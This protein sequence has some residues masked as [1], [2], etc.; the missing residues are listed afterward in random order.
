VAA[1]APA[2]LGGVCVPVIRT[3]MTAPDV[4]DYFYAPLRPRL[5]QDARVAHTRRTSGRQ[6]SVRRPI[7]LYRSLMRIIASICVLCA[8][9][10]RKEN[11]MVTAC[12]LIEIVYH[13]EWCQSG[14]WPLY[15]S[16]TNL[17]EVSM[18]RPGRYLQTER[19]G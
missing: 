2:R 16:D 11:I 9:Y 15:T 6:F 5:C 14:E 17:V 3:V 19:I 18:F 1:Q 10:Y 7:V 4:S 8:W 13:P 12:Y